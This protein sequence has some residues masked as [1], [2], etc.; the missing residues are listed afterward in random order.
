M[1]GRHNRT[2]LTAQVPKPAEMSA[3]ASFQAALPGFL[4]YDVPCIPPSF[5]TTHGVR[6]IMI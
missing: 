6:G 2:F 4:T 3:N 5:D 1:K